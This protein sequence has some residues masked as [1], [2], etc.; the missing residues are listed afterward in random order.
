[1]FQVVIV[2][3]SRFFVFNGF[4]SRCNLSKLVFCILVLRSQAIVGA[5]LS[6]EHVRDIP[7]RNLPCFGQDGAGA[8]GRGTRL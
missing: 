4:V 1:M 3:F 8:Q 2:F 7:M 5:I 6:V